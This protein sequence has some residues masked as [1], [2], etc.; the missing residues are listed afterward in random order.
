MYFRHS[1]YAMR[2]IPDCKKRMTNGQ[3]EVADLA[4]RRTR[5]RR[6]VKSARS[7]KRL[8]ENGVAERQLRSSV[9]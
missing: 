3:S 7:I 8:Y 1:A 5:V 6:E 2:Q 4:R 9:I